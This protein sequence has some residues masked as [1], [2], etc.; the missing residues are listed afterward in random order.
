MFNIGDK[1]VYPM[2]GAGI[3]ESIEE[4]E[5]LGEKRKYYILLLPL[6]NM[7]VMIP[8]DNVDTMGLRD[9]IS[10]EEVEQVLAVLND[11]ESKMPK[12]WNRRYRANM[13]K[14]KSGD[15][16]EVAGVVRNLMLRDKEKGLS[17]GERK[18]LN[19]AKQ[20]LVSEL[21]LVNDSDELSVEELINETIQ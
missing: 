14:I 8:L 5:I 3:I 18:M 21:V 2:H 17:T 20:I 16:Y 10:E 12:N 6:R 15:I 19:N 1:V 4:K 7:K 11:D 13:D 9:I